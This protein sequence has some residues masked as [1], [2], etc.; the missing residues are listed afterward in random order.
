MLALL[1][2]DWN[3][4]KE[5]LYCQTMTTILQAGILLHISQPK[6][7]DPVCIFLG[8]FFIALQILFPKTIFY[9]SS[10]NQVISS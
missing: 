8:H 6:L 10:K 5:Y 7:K 9:F 1:L 2:S 3:I 4:K